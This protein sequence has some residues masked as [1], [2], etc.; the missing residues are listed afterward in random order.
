MVCVCVSMCL[1]VLATG[2]C[3]YLWRPG[4][5]VWSPG[6][7]GSCE[8]RYWEANEGLWKRSKCSSLLSH[9]SSLRV[10]FLNYGAATVEGKLLQGSPNPISHWLCYKVSLCN[11]DGPGNHR[12]QTEPKLPVFLPPLP[13]SACWDG[14]HPPPHVITAFSMLYISTVKVLKVFKVWRF[15]TQKPIPWLVEGT[16]CNHK[17]QVSVW[18]FSVHETCYAE[19]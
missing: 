11:S 5:S 13:P 7:I 6:V 2:T 12:R 16:N 17:L 4:E 15:T 3:M 19:C 14:P 10:P 8:Y 9:L 1:Y 18:I